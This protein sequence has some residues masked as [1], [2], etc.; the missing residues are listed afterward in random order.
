MSEENENLE[1]EQ[2]LEQENDTEA[3]DNEADDSIL[4]KAKK[5]GYKDDGEYTGNPKYKLTPE[6]YLERAEK[7]GTIKKLESDIAN[8]QVAFDKMQRFSQLQVQSAKERAIEELRQKQIKAIDEDGAGASEAFKAF[9]DG[10][11]K[12]ERQ[13]NTEPEPQNNNAPRE[14]TQFYEENPWYNDDVIM[15]GAANA[16]HRKIINEN[17]TMPLSQQLSLVKRR[18]VENFPDKFENPKKKIQSIEGGGAVGGGGNI[19]RKETL[20]SLGFSNADAEDVRR[21]IKAGD[22]KDEDDFIKSYT[23]LNKGKK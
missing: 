15:Q 19:R 22:F 1:T 17:P 14:I 23:L 12:V 10:K 6:Q 11:T 8:M 4:E 5:R 7:G 3:E 20:Q 9:E 21:S 13:Y 18:I 16:L 2:E